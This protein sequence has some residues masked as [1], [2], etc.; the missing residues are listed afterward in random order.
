M[1]KSVLYLNLCVY[2]DD[3]FYAN[4]SILIVPRYIL[5]AFDVFCLFVVYCC[6]CFLGL[7]E[8]EGGGYLFFC[9]FVVGCFLFVYFGGI[10]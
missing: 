7:G 8:G 9:L 2:L 3:H 4:G 10:K 5:L 1:E 6:C